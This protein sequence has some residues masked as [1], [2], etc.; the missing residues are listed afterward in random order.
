MKTQLAVSLALAFAGSVATLAPAGAQTPVPAGY[1]AYYAEVIAAAEKEGA[2]SI[3]ATTDAAEVSDLLAQFRALYPKLK[4]EY[5]DQNST[6]LYSR[7]VAEA[8]AGATAD[9]IWSSAMDLQIKLVNDGYALTYASPEKG[10]LPDWAKWKDQAYGTTA[11]PVVFAYNARLVPEAD[12]PKSHADFAKLIAKQKDAYKGK[13]TSYDPERSGVGFLYITQD[14]QIAPSATWDTVKAMGQASAKFYTST[15]AMIER[16]VSGEHT[17]AYNMIGSYVLQRNRK[18]PNLGYVL[19]KD[20]TQVMSRIGFVSAK[21]KHPNAAKL[22]LDF[23]LSKTGQIELAKKAM[24]SVRADLQDSHGITSLPGAAE[25]TLKPIRVGPELLA[26]L[27][28]ITRLRFIKQWQ[29]TLSAN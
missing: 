8:A 11:E 13:V 12:V 23:V 19:P 22:F 17:L 6:E 18:D 29:K 4:V 14:A 5:A 25:V 9:F 2:L 27:D 7:Y 15:G 16:V 3:Y 10:A 1:P 26:Y 24:T 28:Q 21:A 20:Y